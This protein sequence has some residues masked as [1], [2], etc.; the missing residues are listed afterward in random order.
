[1]GGRLNANGRSSTSENTDRLRA[2]DRGD[3][4]T[5]RVAL[6]PQRNSSFISRRTGAGNDAFSHPLAAFDRPVFDAA[7]CRLESTG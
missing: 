2:G 5:W 4:H 1:M 6:I 7:R 3:D